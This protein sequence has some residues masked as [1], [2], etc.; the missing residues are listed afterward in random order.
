M[1]EPHPLPNLDIL[2]LIKC[3][4][5]ARSCCAAL[6]KGL[7]GIIRYPWSVLLHSCSIHVLLHLGRGKL[8][9]PWSWSTNPAYYFFVFPSRDLCRINFLNGLFPATFSLF[10]SFLQRLNSK[11]VQLKSPMTGFE[12]GPF[13][14]GS[15]RTVY[16]ATPLA[17]FRITFW[18]VIY[19]QLA[20][21]YQIYPIN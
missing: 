9:F 13:G 19:G 5:V 1:T 8:N 14:I 20:I 6:G 15:D 3:L 17:I 16:C 11:Y 10:S 12:P 7:C 2:L 4:I 18:S 21:R